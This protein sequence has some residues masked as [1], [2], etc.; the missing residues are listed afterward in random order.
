MAF[1]YP[2]VGPIPAYTNVPINADFYQPSRFNISALM[3]G[4]TTTVT[5]SVDHNY[6][7][8][9]QVRLI[10]PQQFGTYELNGKQG[11]VIS[12]TSAT[13]VVVNIYSAPFTAFVSSPTAYVTQAQILAIGDINSG[14]TN[15]SG[16][17]NTGTF[18]PGS[19]INIS[20]L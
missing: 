7:V 8:G 20:P 17:T 19:F 16:R 4:Q 5:T 9:Q 15:S 2:T 6:V 11:T 14:V 1:P 3:L 10:I 12:V 18:I 13:Q